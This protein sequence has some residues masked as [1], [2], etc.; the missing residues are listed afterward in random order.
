M[1]RVVDIVNRYHKDNRVNFYKNLFFAIAIPVTN[2]VLAKQF[3]TIFD[4]E[5]TNTVSIMR[6]VLLI[7]VLQAINQMNNKNNDDQAGDLGGYVSNIAIE[8]IVKK[9]IPRDQ[10]SI[11]VSKNIFNINKV[12]EIVTDTF[13]SFKQNVVPFT[14]FYLLASVYFFMTDRRLGIVTFITF[15]LICIV[16]Y[17]SVKGCAKYSLRTNTKIKNYYERLEDTLFNLQIVKVENSENSEIK[18]IIKVKSKIGKPYKSNVRCK[19]RFSFYLNIIFFIYLAVVILILSV[20]RKRGLNKGLIFTIF[21]II[22]QLVDYQNGM[23]DFLRVLANNTAPANRLSWM[24]DTSIGDK[25]NEN[26]KAINNISIVGN[27]VSYKPKGAGYVFKDIDFDIQTGDVVEI[28]GRV[29]SGKTTLI[30]MILGF[31]EPTEGE[32]LINNKKDRLKDLKNDIGFIPQETVLFNKTIMDNIR[33]TKK[34]VSDKKIKDLIISL[35]L[36]DRF[37]KFEKGLYT[38]L[39]SD[40]IQL[41]VGEK[42]MILLLRVLIKDPKIIVIDEPLD[43]MDNQLEK[44]ITQKIFIQRK[45]RM[46]ILLNS[47]RYVNYKANKVIDLDKLKKIDY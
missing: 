4:I 46:V 2:I 31:I 47:N 27:S 32:I 15:I 12:G 21:F 29:G 45:D 35:N 8:N 43:T 38:K 36:M 10:D 18:D 6:V 13:F 41:S 28:R 25:F 14:V 44:I 9:R 17:R 20:L 7:I 5:S 24:L 37:D 34:N 19:S 22:K 3:Q 26:T 33:Y 23:T 40:G 42:K 11:I 16:I 30:N 39:G 1:N